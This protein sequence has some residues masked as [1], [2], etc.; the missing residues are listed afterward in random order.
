MISSSL[1]IRS[2]A[3]AVN[4]GVRGS[5]F[6]SGGKLEHGAF[7][8]R[9]VEVRKQHLLRAQCSSVEP[10]AGYIQNPPPTASVAEKSAR[11]HSSFDH[12]CSR[13]MGFNIDWRR[14]QEN[15]L[16]AATFPSGRGSRVLSTSP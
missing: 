4:C 14:L 15:I 6:K 5:N 3:I 12:R 2:A 7:G 9:E 1:Q 11:A 8:F 13:R 10:A 16:P